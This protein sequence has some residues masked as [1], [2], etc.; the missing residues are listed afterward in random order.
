MSNFNMTERDVFL[1][2]Y[3]AVINTTKNR[4]MLAARV[5]MD[6]DGNMVLTQEERTVADRF[7]A[8]DDLDRLLP[9]LR[10]KAVPFCVNGR[11][12]AYWDWIDAAGFYLDATGTQWQ[13]M[14][15]A[16][17]RISLDWAND[18]ISDSFGSAKAA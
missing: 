8:A 13:F 7:I 2:N 18:K 4:I 6:T 10:H 11:S 15:T 12:S 16:K 1:T 14:T 3:C 17:R 9:W 5:L